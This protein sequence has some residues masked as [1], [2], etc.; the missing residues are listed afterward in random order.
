MA[1]RR[2]TVD[3]YLGR[4][5]ARV[6]VP[7]PET[8][9]YSATMLEFPGCVT[10]GDSREEAL[11]RLED[12]ARSWL[13]AALD[14]GQ[15]VPEPSAEAAYSGRL[16]LRLPKDLHRRAAEA[17]ERDGVS[18]NQYIGNALAE[19]LGATRLADRLVEETHKRILA[20]TYS[21]LVDT[22]A[23]LGLDRIASTE[24]PP[25]SMPALPGAGATREVN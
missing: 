16:V 21:V 23:D 15:Q 14:L 24:G 18:L 20:T 8:G 7:D 22:F 13:E 17:A 5:Y 10:Q 1:T 3:E 2:R 12:A 25:I 9:T 19:R 6:V 11:S 4:P